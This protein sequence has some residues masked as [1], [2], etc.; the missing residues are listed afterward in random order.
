MHNWK[1][2]SINRTIKP[3]AKRKWW[4]LTYLPWAFSWF[5]WLFRRHQSR[6]CWGDRQVRKGYVYLVVSSFYH[7]LVPSKIQCDPFY[8]I[9]SLRRNQPGLPHHLLPLPH[10]MIDMEKSNFPRYLQY[11][12][13]STPWKKPWIHT[14]TMNSYHPTERPFLILDFNLLVPTYALSVI[15]MM[16]KHK[17][18]ALFAFLEKMRITSLM[19]MNAQL[20]TFQY[21]QNH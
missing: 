8:Y 1:H 15:C 16:G 21:Q 17:N 2:S 7:L 4:I 13:R 14:K 5:S 18:R 10:T 3:S 9:R 11:S 20:K 12:P 6:V 19:E